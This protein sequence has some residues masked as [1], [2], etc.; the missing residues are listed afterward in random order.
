MMAMGRDLTAA[1]G[2][3][4]AAIIIFQMPISL[5]CLDF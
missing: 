3:G 4:A 5:Q 2:I 1:E